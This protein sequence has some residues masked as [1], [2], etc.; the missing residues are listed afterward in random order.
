VAP[1]PAIVIALFF[2]MALN[3][4][5]MRQEFRSG[6]TF[7]VKILLRWAI[8]LLGLRIALGEIVALGMATGALVI[9]AMLVTMASGFLF[10]RVFGQTTSYGALAGAG[11]AVCGASAT[12]ATSAVLP[13]YPGK[14]ADVA[15]VVPR[16]E[17]RGTQRPWHGY[18]RGWPRLV[19]RRET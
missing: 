9:A 6:V 14:Q 15:F 19:D 2:G 16:A 17:Q 7:C 5:A 11:T 4:V 18:W 3:P 8:A 10:A 13:D 12:L 1:L